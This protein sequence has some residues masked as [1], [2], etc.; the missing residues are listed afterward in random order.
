MKKDKL[1]VFLTCAE[2]VS[3]VVM[4][5]LFVMKSSLVIS[6]ES[7]IFAFD[8]LLRTDAFLE[9]SFLD[10]ALKFNLVFVICLLAVLLLIKFKNTVKIRKI[11]VAVVVFLVSASLI[12]NVAHIILYEHCA[13]NEI[14]SVYSTGDEDFSPVPA[15]YAKYFPYFDMMDEITDKDVSYEYLDSA[16]H[17]GKYILMDT[18]CYDLEVSFSYEQMQTKSSWLMNQYIFTKG[19][20]NYTDDANKTVFIEP[21]QNEKYGC[22]IYKQK[23][24]YEIWFIE[25]DSCTILKYKGFNQVFDYTENEILE[26]AAEIYSNQS[27]DGSK[28][29]KK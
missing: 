19:K 9:Y 1:V 23:D 28:P 13:R 2:I 3:A 17:L 14:W 12:T 29:L 5:V 21:I 11:C 27:G 10:S 4:I 16:T 24:S 15:E 18:W 22:T 25:K 26:E 7:N 20:P 8:Y 6:D